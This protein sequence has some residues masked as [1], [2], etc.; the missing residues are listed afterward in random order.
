MNYVCAIAL[1]CTPAAAWGGAGEEFFE[2]KIRPLLVDR[3][4]ECH[5][6][7]KTKGGLALDTREG[8]QKGGDSGPVVV[9]GKPEES[10]LISAV[11]YGDQDL[12]MPPEKAG[13]KLS[14]ADIALLTEWV[15]MGAPD[16]RGSV[17]K[18]GGMKPDEARNW[19]A[20]QPLPQRAAALTPEKIDAFINEPLA[21]QSLT[22]N[23]PADRRTLTR[24]ATYDL[25][26]LPPTPEEVEAFA[27]DP[28][29][30]GWAKVID[31]LLA[32]PQ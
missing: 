13:G 30:E 19:W 27:G 18:L 28:S 15:R 4:Y 26:G 20:F 16:P 6:G 31:R 21:A 23:P 14:E 24:R 5:S 11:H 10:L 7:E 17:A 2:S 32:S 22:A 25:T 29:P 3:C 1:L 9:P 8:W 12:A